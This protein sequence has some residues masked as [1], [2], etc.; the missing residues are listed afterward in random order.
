ML[1]NP[2][3][4]PRSGLSSGGTLLLALAG[5]GTALLLFFTLPGLS[6]S[7]AADSRGRGAHDALRAED[8]AEAHGAPS[9]QPAQLLVPSGLDAQADEKPAS[10]AVDPAAGSALLAASAG[11]DAA[12]LTAEPADTGPK[13]T[14]ESRKGAGRVDPIQPGALRAQA[15]KDAAQ[16]AEKAREEAIARGEAPPEPNR[17]AK[18]GAKSVA[19]GGKGGG[20]KGAGGPK[21]GKGK[22]RG[23]GGAAVKSRKP[24]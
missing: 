16:R 7:R 12:A 22:K 13:L 18:R 21:D 8:P 23:G 9:E 15:R 2:R 10:L 20:G 6:S 11:G 1:R 4:S 19:D 14:Y 17:A 24:Q 3:P 5:A